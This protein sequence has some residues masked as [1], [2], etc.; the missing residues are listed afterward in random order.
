MATIN[1]G[2][3]AIGALSF[4]LLMAVKVLYLEEDQQKMTVRSLI[5]LWL[6]VPVKISSHA[7]RRH[8]ARIFVPKATLRWWNLFLAEH[9]PKRPRGRPPKEAV[10]VELSA[11]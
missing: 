4:N 3:Y 2:Y 7:H 8:K 6:T 1:S 10:G 5:R 9:Y 11:T